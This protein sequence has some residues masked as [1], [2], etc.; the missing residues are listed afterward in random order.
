MQK[1][2]WVLLLGLV[3]LCL[4]AQTGQ[5]IRN[6]PEKPRIGTLAPEKVDI[7]DQSSSPPVVL[8]PNKV[9]LF[10]SVPHKIVLKPVPADPNILAPFAL[11]DAPATLFDL[12]K[13]PEA[14]TFCGEKI[15]LNILEVHSRFRHELARCSR[16][17][18]SV[19]HYARR[20]QTYQQSFEELLEANGLPKELF[21]L[22]VAES[23]LANLTSPKGAKGFWQFMPETAKRFGLEV[24]ETVDER[25]HP[26]KSCIAACTYLKALY[27][28]FGSWTLAA[29]A[30]NMGEGALAN[31]I[32]AQGKN[33]YFALQ[34]NSETAQY[35]YRI[36]AL[37]YVLK[38]PQAFGLSQADANNSKPL[39]FR[40]EAVDYNIDD[41]ADFAEDCGTDYATLKALNPWLIGNRLLRKSDKIYEIYLPTAETRALEEWVER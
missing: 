5:Q 7:L 18:Y 10:G 3:C 1:S 34:L 35:V 37:K 21:Y 24:S 33:D 6:V 9:D 13:L 40:I 30:Y 39:A 2:A 26:L 22:S 14:F 38:Y 31:N 15:P 23:G 28:Q 16:A 36:A 8:V 25:L 41:L 19:R 17:G 32:A 4:P 29:A 12:P 27:Q 20:A 11:P